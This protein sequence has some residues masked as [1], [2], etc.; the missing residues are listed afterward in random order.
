MFNDALC[1]KQSRSSS[2]E[3]M[4]PNTSSHSCLMGWTKVTTSQYS[5]WTWCRQGERFTKITFQLMNNVRQICFIRTLGHGITP[6]EGSVNGPKLH[7][8]SKWNICWAQTVLPSGIFAACP[9]T[10]TMKGTTWTNTRTCWLGEW[11]GSGGTDQTK[12]VRLHVCTNPS[13]KKSLL[14]NAWPSAMVKWSL[15]DFAQMDVHLT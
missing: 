9:S 12:L 6:L 7:G 1:Q 14:W 3:S 2:V 4:P 13:P 10:T 8:N 11:W 15:L 5:W